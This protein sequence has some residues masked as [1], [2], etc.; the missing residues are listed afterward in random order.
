MIQMPQVILD[1][2]WAKVDKDGPIP[3]DRADL[4]NCWVWTAYRRP[5]GYGGF[6]F[7]SRPGGSRR[8]VRAHR[9]AYE[10]ST[11]RISPELELDHLC[12]NAAC[13]RPSHLEAVTHRVNT[14]RGISGAIIAETKRRTTHCPQGHPYDLFNTYITPNGRRNCRICRT[15]ARRAHERRR[16]EIIPNEESTP[17]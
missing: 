2:F 5:D 7:G 17:G 14:Q 11:G 15:D 6:S 3:G 4:G 9:F 16:L 12:R 1:R 13:V 10:I 8:M